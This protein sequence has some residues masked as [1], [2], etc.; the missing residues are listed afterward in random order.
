MTSLHSAAQRNLSIVETAGF[1]D[2][3]LLDSGDGRKLERFGGIVVDR[4]EPQA[5]W[6]PRLDKQKWQQAHAVFAGDGEDEAGKWRVDR[7]VPD[8]TRKC[9]DPLRS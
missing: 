5:L 2:Y 7:P 6:R 3:R 1:D 9:A 8:R 4:P